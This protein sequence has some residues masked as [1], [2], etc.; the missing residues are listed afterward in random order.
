MVQANTGIPW[1]G[2]PWMGVL[3]ADESSGSSFITP[4]NSIKVK[5]NVNLFNPKPVN[6]K[7]QFDGTEVTENDE[8]L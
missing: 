8:K 1:D 6:I 7:N 2:E 4:I 3:E 5:N